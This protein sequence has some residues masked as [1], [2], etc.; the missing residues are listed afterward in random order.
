MLTAQIFDHASRLRSFRLAAGVRDAL[1]AARGR[2]TGDAPA[3][4]AIIQQGGD[5]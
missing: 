4:E 1:D 5:N 3:G 2:E